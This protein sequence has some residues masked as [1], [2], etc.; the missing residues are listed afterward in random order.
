MVQM[1]VVLFAIAS[2][3]LFAAVA[4]WCFMVE[5]VNNKVLTAFVALFVF[6]GSFVLG[7]YVGHGQPL[8][9]GVGRDDARFVAGHYYET[10]AKV[11]YRVDTTLKG[12]T[13]AVKDGASEKVLFISVA[14][15]ELPPR[16]TVDEKGGIVPLPPSLPSSPPAQTLVPS[17]PTPPLPPPMPPLFPGMR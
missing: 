14:E 5:G 8:T 9:I 15:K 17:P 1:N 6:C 7:G 16:F 10:L 11:P 2:I 3:A 4:V 13:F 12:A